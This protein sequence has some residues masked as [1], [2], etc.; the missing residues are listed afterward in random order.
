MLNGRKKKRSR[1]EPL[2]RSLTIF[3][4]NDAGRPTKKKKKRKGDAHYE[5]NNRNNNN[6]KKKRTA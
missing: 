4:N 1:F 2:S 3:K 6:N 5:R